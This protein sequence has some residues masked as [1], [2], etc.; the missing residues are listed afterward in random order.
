MLFFST[1]RTHTCLHAPFSS[2]FQ[3]FFFWLRSNGERA[4]SLSIREA[5]ILR[6]PPALRSNAVAFVV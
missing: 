3:S 5:E 6:P 4:K 2:A 1:A